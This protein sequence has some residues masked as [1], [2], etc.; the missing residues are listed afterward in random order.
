MCLPLS[1]RPI[2]HVRKD[3]TIAQ[4]F[5][6]AYKLAQHLAHPAKRVCSFPNL[7]IHGQ[8]GSEPLMSYWPWH[9]TLLATKCCTNHHVKDHK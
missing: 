4:C 7:R 5:K 3:C 9:R 1:D 8:N 2:C 6:L